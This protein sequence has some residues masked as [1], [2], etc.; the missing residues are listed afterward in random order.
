MSIVKRII[1][2]LLAVV[3]FCVF[4]LASPLEILTEEEELCF[5]EKPFL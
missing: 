1:T 4:E 3:S 2:L 5:N